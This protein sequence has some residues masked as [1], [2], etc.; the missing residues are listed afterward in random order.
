M[1][2]NIYTLEDM[3]TDLKC[4]FADLVY[5]Q[6]KKEEYALQG[7]DT[8][9]DI[10]LLYD[11]IDTFEQKLKNLKYRFDKMVERKLIY[12]SVIN[13]TNVER[14]YEKELYLNSCDSKFLEKVKQ[15]I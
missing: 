7:C 10:D 4:K 6:Y 15:F 8:K 11:Y 2:Y 14:F 3:L 12:P 1:K 13:K 5:T 9:V